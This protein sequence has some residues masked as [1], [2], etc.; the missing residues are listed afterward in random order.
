MVEVGGGEEE[1]EEELEVFLLPRFALVN[2]I[3]IF[4]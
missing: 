4:S 2:N 3:V 1:E